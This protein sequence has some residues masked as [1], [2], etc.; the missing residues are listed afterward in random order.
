MMR[1]GATVS[2]NKP[3]SGLKIIKYFLYWAQMEN[4]MK[5]VLTLMTI[6]Y[7]WIRCS[8]TTWLHILQKRDPA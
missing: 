5:S 2:P 4:K 1:A 3:C 7:G 6:G 8:E